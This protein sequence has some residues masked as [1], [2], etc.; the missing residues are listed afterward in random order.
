MQLFRRAMEFIKFLGG[1]LVYWAF[2]GDTPYHASAGMPGGGFE[3]TRDAA[4]A[5]FIGGLVAFGIGALVTT[6]LL[7][8]A[9]ADFL[10]EREKERESKTRGSGR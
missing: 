8:S 5:L 10:E 7:F 3:G 4:V 6:V 2:F 9:I 1:L